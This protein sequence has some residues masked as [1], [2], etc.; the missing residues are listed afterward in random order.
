MRDGETM[1]RVRAEGIHQR[2]GETIRNGI[3]AGTNPPE[4]R[5]KREVETEN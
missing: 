5:R 3:G 4:G 2:E 1:G